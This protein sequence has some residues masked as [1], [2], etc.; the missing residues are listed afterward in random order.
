[1]IFLY[2]YMLFLKLNIN[3][4]SPSVYTDVGMKF[5]METVSLNIN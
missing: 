5:D 1:M 4:V 2:G 3:N